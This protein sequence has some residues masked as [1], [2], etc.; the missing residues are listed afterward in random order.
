MK[1]LATLF[2]SVV[3][4]WQAQAQQL[5]TAKVSGQGK[6]LILIHGLYCS[7]D[8]WKETVEHLKDRYECHVLT[9]AGFGGNAP[10][11]SDHFL[12]SVKDDVIA[13]SKK[14]NKPVL[15]GHSMGAFISLWAGATS[16]NTFDKIIAV[17]GVPFLPE[18]FMPGST[19]ETSKPMANAAKA[20]MVNQTPAQ[21][22][23]GQKQ[24]LPMMISNADRI[25]QVVKIAITA[26]ANTQAEV[27]Y[28]MYTTDLRKAVAQTDC[29]VL[30][31]GTWIAYKQYG[32]THESIAKTYEAQ[33]AGVKNHKI[34]ISDTAKHF[35]FYDDPAWFNEKLDNFLK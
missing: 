25:N 12:Q 34:E 27:M 22:E 11:L 28:E 1:K 10:K 20:R 9:L 16:P 24:Y 32:V 6:P 18:L 15:I 3:F 8:V 2:V 23:E 30:F 19:P 14:L 13:Y 17:D 7:G 5:F 31:M 35:I 4:V 33:F 29:P 26:D 21:I